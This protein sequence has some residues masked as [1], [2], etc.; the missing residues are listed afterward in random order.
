[1]IIFKYL[2]TIWFLLNT[3][4]ATFIAGIILLTFGFF[5]D[6]LRLLAFLEKFWGKW[7][8][9]AAGL[10]IQVT[11]LE[12]L[13]D[14]HQYI[15]APNHASLLDVPI[16]MTVLNRPILFMAKKELY[17]IPFFGWMLKA[18]GMIEVNRQNKKEAKKSVERAIETLKEK[19]ASMLIYPEGTRSKTGELL[20]LKKGCFIMAIKS[21]LS[22][23]PVTLIGTNSILKKHSLI[24]NPGKISMQFH[25]PI[26]TV[27]M[28]IEDRDILL[29]QVR[30]KLIFGLTG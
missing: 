24:L 13:N 14:D 3:V 16:T 10:K 22:V 17:R 6:N 25:P 18:A 15:F 20:P 4:I 19:N 26:H 27:E 11:G 2:R 5:D 28:D 8:V 23:I 29:E 7:L 21:G 1:M 12:N 30:E 9:N